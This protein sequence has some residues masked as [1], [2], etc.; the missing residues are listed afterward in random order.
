MYRHSPDRAMEAAER[1]RTASNHYLASVLEHVIAECGD[2]VAFSVA[3][4]AA[5][6]SA[7]G[8]DVRQI[9]DRL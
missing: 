8:R 2:L 5:K 3:S 7:L 4:G 9:T 1:A 6:A